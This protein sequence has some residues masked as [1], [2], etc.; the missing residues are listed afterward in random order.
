MTDYGVQPTGYVR[1]PLAEVLAE[2]ETDMIELFGPGVIQTS[3][4]V[5]GQLNGLVAD[6][7]SEIDEQNLDVY[8]SYD[9][10]QAEGLRLDSLGKLRIVTRADDQSDSDYRK[11]ITNE[12]VTR[13]EIA[14]L[15]T[16][17]SAVTGVTFAKIYVNES[18]ATFDYGQPTG[19]VAAV[20]DGGEDSDVA[21]VLHKYVIPG[22]FT[23]GEN[24]INAEIN[25]VCRALNVTRPD[26][27]EVTLQV[28]GVV[29]EDRSECPSPPEAAIQVLIEEGWLATRTNGMNVTHRNIR[30][31]VEAVY[32][33]VEI[34]SV[35]GSRDAGA[36]ASS[37]EI[38]FD[39]I[40]DLVVSVTLT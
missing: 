27:V 24:V 11:A 8:Q 32:P 31:F 15:E 16:S 3:Q 36:P 37:V 14:D 28:D 10:D 6:L 23:Y 9:P 2:I 1:K 40:A 33:D 21:E 38:E 30:S 39:E 13:Y 4:S 35:S 7:V 5:L 22:I 12:G 25:G 20:V 26:H 19:S 18:G 34:T 29:S 17:L